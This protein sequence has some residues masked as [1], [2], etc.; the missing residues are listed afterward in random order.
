MKPLK[1]LK[2]GDDAAGAIK[3]GVYSLKN[4][5][6]DIVRTGRS[7]NL[8]RRKQ[9]HAR[10]PDLRDFKFQSEFATDAY[11]EQ[12]GL[13]HLLYLRNPQAMSTNGGFNK[14]AP[15]AARNPRMSQ[16][17]QAALT[18]RAGR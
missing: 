8:D 16:Y 7:K 1:L 13:E 18:F 17:I 4:A 3:G 11:D 10:D 12:R 2:Y 14:I 15:I 6:D 9:D 5:D